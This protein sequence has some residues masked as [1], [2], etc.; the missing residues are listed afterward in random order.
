MIYHINYNHIWI[1]VID[2]YWQEY[3][4]MHLPTDET[5]Q[6]TTRHFRMTT[7][8]ATLLWGRT[9]YK[10]EV[11]FTGKGSPSL[12]CFKLNPISLETSTVVKDFIFDNILILCKSRFIKIMS[13]FSFC[14]AS[15]WRNP[16][17]ANVEIYIILGYRTWSW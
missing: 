2:I 5:T 17:T 13:I 16:N 9:G 4:L 8:R 11:H 7:E 3:N 10:Y 15:R 6:C 1:M 14:R 12:M